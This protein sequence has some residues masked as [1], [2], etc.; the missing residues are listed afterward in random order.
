GAACSFVAEGL[1]VSI[2]NG[3]LAS[4]FLHLP[5]V[6]RPFR[7]ALPYTFGLAYRA[8]EPRPQVVTAF[9]EHLKQRLNAQNA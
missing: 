1:G 2:V 4:H 5:I 8:N 3:L 6:T 7:P 9:A